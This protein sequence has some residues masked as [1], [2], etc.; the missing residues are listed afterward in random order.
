MTGTG[1]N[2]IRG[3]CVNDFSAGIQIESNGNHLEACFIGTDP[4]GTIAVPNGTG[5][6]L[7]RASPAT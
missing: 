1:G 6:V 4:T 5:V 2:T 7:T 3:V